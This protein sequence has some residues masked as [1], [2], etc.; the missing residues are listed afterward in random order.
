M[1]F[2]GFTVVM[3]RNNN[4]YYSVTSLILKVTIDKY[5]ILGWNSYLFSGNNKKKRNNKII[6]CLLHQL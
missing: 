1:E 4:I 3:K 5:I 6:H 2:K